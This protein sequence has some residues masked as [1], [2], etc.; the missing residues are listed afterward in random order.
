M[1]SNCTFV[2]P[3]FCACCQNLVLSA[4]ASAQSSSQSAHT[5]SVVSPPAPRQLRSSS[6]S[7]SASAFRPPQGTSRIVL[8]P[9]QG[10]SQFGSSDLISLLMNTSSILAPLLPSHRQTI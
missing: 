4:S 2:I 8:L 10:R 3:C 1:L 9:A 6:G 7:F 5:M